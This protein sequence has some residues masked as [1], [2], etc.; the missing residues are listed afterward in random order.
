[1]TQ[2][3]E[4]YLKI[5]SFLSEEGPVRVTDIALRLKV[6]KSSVITALKALKALGLVEHIRYGTISMTDR[7]IRRAAEIRELYNFL[8]VFLRN[9]GVSFETAEKDACKMEHILSPETIEKLKHLAGK[10][11]HIPE[12]C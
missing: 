5:I 6:A 2:S 12:L 1:M 9:I 4:D 11:N 8:T 10:H 7:G 3:L